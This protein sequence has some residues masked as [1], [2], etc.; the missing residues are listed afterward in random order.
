MTNE[1]QLLT[2]DQAAEML[3]LKPQTLQN[4]RV[5]K[6]ESLPYLKYGRHVRYRLEDIQR[7]LETKRVS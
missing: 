5:T 1:L 2:P 6:A 7:W 3:G 4:W